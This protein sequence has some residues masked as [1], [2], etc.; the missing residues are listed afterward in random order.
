MGLEAEL[1]KL[2]R[3]RLAFVSTVGAVMCVVLWLSRWKL[4]SH[5]G[6]QSSI[7]YLDDLAHGYH[8]LSF[9]TAALLFR[10]KSL[11]TQTI[12]ALDLL[13]FA[14]NI[15]VRVIATVGVAGAG[16]HFPGVEGIL[17]ALILHGIFVP[18]GPAI[19]WALGL[20]ATFSFP[21]AQWL[22]RSL[23]P[24]VGAHWNGQAAGTFEGL[25]ILN[26]LSIGFFAVLGI[27]T[28][29]T[30]YGLMREV[31]KA[32]RL[33]NFEV[34]REIDSGGMGTILE[35]KHQTLKR[36][37]ALKVLRPQAGIGEEALNRFEREAELASRLTHPNTISIYDF[38][39]AADGT[40]YYAMELLKGFNLQR[41]V[42][43]HGP[44]QA[45]RTIHFM[46][47]AIGSMQE[48]HEMG[49][50]HRDIKPGNLFVTQ[51]GG[52]FD[53][54][55]VLDFGLAKLRRNEESASQNLTEAGRI[56]GTPHFM[57]P[58]TLYGSDL[59]DHR[60]D[61]YSL[62]AV[63]Y[64]LVTGR[65]LFDGGP[66]S[67]MKAHAEKEPVPPSQMSEIEIPQALDEW[68]SKALQKNPEDRFS[69]V[70]AMQAE[71]EPLRQ[72]FRWTQE[73][74]RAWW[75]THYPQ[76]FTTSESF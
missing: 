62:G 20:I 17:L 1:D 73:E 67:L 56:F 72:K 35:A 13:L 50:V 4:H 11:H 12:L 36:Q 40:L 10:V 69:S 30:L 31:Y 18:T 26:T 28:N 32:R 38:G 58:E 63:A 33:G 27:L 22:G 46:A 3:E 49:V 60:A 29:R 41:M 59:L 19:P 45:G 68:I 23:I 74:A 8:T 15:L 51:R 48:A 70:V 66:R 6:I 54:L 55:K 34:L 65:H 53:F 21:V 76:I 75:M 2:R 57:A 64:W 71:L 44:M 37:T 43:K 7:P 14:T 25:V 39:R 61:I 47:Q 5:A 42:E 24:V 16:D 52:L 9:I